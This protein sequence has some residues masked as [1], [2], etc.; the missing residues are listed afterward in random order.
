MDESPVT[1]EGCRPWTKP[2]DAYEP[3]LLD[4][5]ILH[6][7]DMNLLKIEIEPELR[8]LTLWFEWD[9]DY[10]PDPFRDAPLARLDLQRARVVDWDDEPVEHLPPGVGREVHGLDFYPPN[11][12]HFQSYNVTFTAK[13]RRVVLTVL[14]AD[15]L[16]R[17]DL[18]C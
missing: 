1:F 17:H 9:P 2:S 13:F 5:R 16:R 4:G 3:E 18:G 15:S 14:P 10:L 8:Q 12:L 11:L 7:H 6:F